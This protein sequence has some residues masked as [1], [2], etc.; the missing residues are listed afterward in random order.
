MNDQ[1]GHGN[2]LNQLEHKENINY[3]D[4]PHYKRNFCGIGN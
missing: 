3:V 2:T 1:I 4:N